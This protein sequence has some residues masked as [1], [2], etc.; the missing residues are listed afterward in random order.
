MLYVTENVT[1]RCVAAA[2]ANT[3]NLIER[4]H[5]SSL[6]LWIQD[7]TTNFSVAMLR[8]NDHEEIEVHRL[9]VNVPTAPPCQTLH[10]A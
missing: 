1:F 9:H 2:S 3:P 8:T 7:V 5:R 4:K 10:N 6:P